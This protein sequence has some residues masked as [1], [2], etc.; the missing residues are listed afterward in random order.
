MQC[1]FLRISSYTTVKKFMILLFIKR[2]T[3]Q[4]SVKKQNVHKTNMMKHVRKIIKKCNSLYRKRK[5]KILHHDNISQQQWSSYRQ[6]LVKKEEVRTS[7]SVDTHM[8][9]KGMVIGEKMMCIYHDLAIGGLRA[10]LG[11]CQ[12]LVYVHVL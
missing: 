5:P 2:N 3:I 4:Q 8:C 9:R 1:I 10:G 12:G 11:I 6:L 7:E